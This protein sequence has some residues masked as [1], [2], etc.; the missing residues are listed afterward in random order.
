MTEP[1]LPPACRTPPP[2][3]PRP[4]DCSSPRSSR[5]GRCRWATGPPAPPSHL[6]GGREADAQ[7][8]ARCSFPSFVP[9]V[10]LFLF[11]YFFCPVCVWTFKCVLKE[12]G[13]VVCMGPVAKNSSGLTY[14]EQMSCCVILTQDTPWGSSSLGS[15]YARLS[16]PCCRGREEEGRG[17]CLP[18]LDGLRGGSVC[19]IMW[20]VFWPYNPPH[21]TS[22]G[23]VLRGECV[24]R[25][26]LHLHRW[27]FI[28]ICVCWWEWYKRLHISFAKHQTGMFACIC[29][30][31]LMW[32]E[33][34][35]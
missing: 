18:G 30:V 22:L 33:Q 16:F 23:D 12:K 19:V 35:N 8:M 9:W 11:I 10:S 27:F 29:Q 5:C 21:F 6:I 24:Q 25:D 4:A 32:A 15:A 20:W 1:W 31:G 3:C 14:V 34:R 2:C 13:P 28:F 26:L 7:V 17:K